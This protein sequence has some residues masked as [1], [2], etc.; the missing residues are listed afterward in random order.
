MQIKNTFAQQFAEAAQAANKAQFEVRFNA[1]QRGLVNQM[2]NEIEKVTNDG[3]DRKIAE[4]QKKRDK[5]FDR[6]DNLRELQNDIRTNA[7]RFLEISDKANQAIAAADADEDGN[8]SDDEREA[9]NAAIAGI[10]EEVYKIKIS[11]NY[12]GEVNDGNLGN[13]LRGAFNALENLTATTGVIDEEGTTPTT[14]DNRA[15]LDTLSDISTRANNYAESSSYLNENLNQLVTDA[16]TKAY[17]LEADLSKL[18]LVEL[19]KKQ[20]EIDDINNRYSTLIKSISLAFE[21]Q[22]GLGDALA[23][24]TTYEPEAGSI[25][26]IFA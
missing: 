3:T 16:T 11:H 24:G 9:L 14:N 10:K 2:N 22:S 4:V 6:A 5:L 18:T 23:A 21:V 17:D 20:T 13:M 25:L 12:G 26:N 7:F 1:V 15:I 8:L 19:E